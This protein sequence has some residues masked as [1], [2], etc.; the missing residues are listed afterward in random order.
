MFKNRSFISFTKFI[1]TNIKNKL[2]NMYTKLSQFKHDWFFTKI[3]A[4]NIKTLEY[5]SSDTLK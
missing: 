3:T 4:K 2:Y 5:I 1:Y